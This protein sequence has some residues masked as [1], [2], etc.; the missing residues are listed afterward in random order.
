MKDTASKYKDAY[1][2]RTV[3]ALTGINPI[4]LRTWE[5]RY[6]LIEPV[7]TPKGHRL[8]TKE[9]IAMLSRVVELLDR[10]IPISRI[11]YAAITED[12][13]SALTH[14]QLFWQRMIDRMIKAIGKFDES[15]LESAYSEAMSL[16]PIETVTQKL[17][18]PML[19]K[20]GERWEAGE[21]TVAEEHFFGVYL[22]NKLGARF[23]HKKRLENAPAFVTAC[24]PGE[25]HEIGLL[26]FALSAYDH[27]Y[28]CILLGADIPLAELPGAV[29]QSAASGIVLSA[30]IISD[31][32]TFE[33][34]LASLVGSTPVPVFV[35][36]IGSLMYKGAIE[37]AGARVLGTDFDLSFRLIAETIAP[38]TTAKINH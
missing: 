11:T 26:L 15:V 10:G 34:E 3:S 38:A 20:L 17:L 2:I 8:Y 7:R 12:N 24:I 5:R 36:G 32:P 6:H 33:L 21:G 31:L 18:L 16:Y 22:R 9:H 27:G 28:R 37:K 25:R 35:G 29:Q 19:Q 14:E 4:T 30:S 23:H 1:P 13:V